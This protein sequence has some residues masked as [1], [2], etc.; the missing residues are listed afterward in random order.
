MWAGLE[1]R[2]LEEMTL[3]GMRYRTVLI[4]VALLASVFADV[5]GE[6]PKDRSPQETPGSNSGARRIWL[7]RDLHL[8]TGLLLSDT[9]APGQSLLLCRDGFSMVIGDRTLTA[10]RAVVWVVAGASQENESATTREVR[11]YL[12]G[13]VSDQLDGDGPESDLKQHVLER[14]QAIVV[15]AGIRGEIFITADKRETA[16]SRT[17][18]LY[19]EAALAFQKAGLSLPSTPEQA[20]QTESTKVRKPEIDKPARGA[21]I[22]ISP[23]TNVTP[24]VERLSK[25][26]EEII[27]FMGRWHISWQEPNDSDEHVDPIELQADN[28]IVWRATADDEEP[29]GGLPAAQE[30]GVTAVYVS[31]DV[32]MTQGQRTIRASD[33]YYDLQ[34]RR[35]LARNVVM[36]SYDPGRNIPIYV[37]AGE[38]R[39]V[40][41]DTF[42]AED[43]SLTS[44]E[45]WTPQVSL[46]AAEI[47]VVD[48]QVED[49]TG[50]LLPESRYEVELRDV[51]FKVGDTTLLRV[52]KVHADRAVTALPI[53]SLHVG[54][55]STYGTSIET[56]WWL[57]RLLGLREPEGT[58]GTIT[59]DYYGDR[60]VGGGV[61]LSYERENYFGSVLGYMIEDHG[62]DRLSRTRKDV[63]VPEDTRGIFRFQHRH[64]LPYNWQ[65]T[66]EIAYLSDE[67]FLE[68]FYRT[69]YN[70]GKEQ[71]TLLYLKRI[72]DNWGLAFLGKTRINDFMDQV[73][74]LPTAE[75]HL[76]GQSLFDDRL[77]FYSD[78]QAS[79]Y[80]YRYAPDNPMDEPDEYFTFTGTR[81][82]LDMPLTAGVVRVVP[83]VA[84][85]FGYDEGTGFGTDLDED[86][87]ENE[88]AVAIGEAGVR[89]SARPFWC[90][91][92]D[93]ESRLWD[94]HQLRHIIRPSI[95]AVSYEETD[96]VAEQRDTLDFGISQRFQTKRGP[97]D[98]RRTVDWL[99]WDLDFVWVGDSGDREAGPD[100]FIWSEPY[101]PLVN[102]D[103][104]VI[105]PLDRRTTGLF[106]PRQNYASTEVVLRLTDTTSVLSDVYYDMQNGIVEQLDVGFSRLCW[107]NL[108]YYVGSRY[109]RNVDNTLG[110]KGSTALTFAATY[111]LDPRYTLVLAEQFDFDY[112]E[113][114]RTD[115]TLIRKYHR[116]NLALTFSVDESVDEQRIVLS[117]WPEGVPELAIG[118]RRYMDLGASDVYQ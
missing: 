37:R 28:L 60:G 47:H 51:R 7:E 8:K 91:Y 34:K 40:A 6:G 105:P 19:Q 13:E 96:I 85:T 33:L 93:V 59:V 4:G 98:R 97:A 65:L 76:M 110:E 116:T 14:N 86:A 42:E 18:P 41:E 104:R 107:P 1:A 57:S 75:Y 78:N 94:L 99:E 25:D 100:R 103:G 73:E 5:R 71:E 87:A 53:R 15:E 115:A 62:E 84:G 90:V 12:G 3:A 54:N 20:S 45:F 102:R 21:T 111:I 52:P 95:T 56:R 118:A 43:V 26:G 77:T 67:N 2:L 106:G 70:V 72:E 29:N 68:Q 101:I 46:A 55:S 11:V 27:T 10:D 82:E 50:G 32:L 31:G 88:D 23:V 66:A 35:A 79:R 22:S 9:V 39:Q 64:F 44:S 48:R 49:E 117:L 74:E 36:R 58:D 38:L 63:D 113:N 108:T 69:E 16:A 17:L 92:P 89:M 109:L 81:N 112:D 114:V 83:F 24:K 61:D 80:R 30:E